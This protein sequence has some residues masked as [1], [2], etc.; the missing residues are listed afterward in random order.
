MKFTIMKFTVTKNQPRLGLTLS[1]VKTIALKTNANCALR[2]STRTYQLRLKTLK[3]M[4]ASFHR[5]TGADE[6]CN[7][8][9]MYWYD[10]GE[11][12]STDD[13]AYK[14]FQTSDYPPETDDPLPKEKKMEMK[15]EMN[16]ESRH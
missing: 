7:F 3:V 15:R 10:P 16:G 11:G 2:F 9:L 5:A 12:K 8:Y 13:C 4:T 6:M 1:V 14:E